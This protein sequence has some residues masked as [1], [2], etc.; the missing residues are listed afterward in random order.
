MIYSLYGKTES[1]YGWEIDHIRPKSMMG[2]DFISNLQPLQWQNNRSKGDNYPSFET[3]VSSS[4]NKNILQ[5]KR[6]Y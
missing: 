3:V 6:W 4:G 1:D 2:S 5:Q